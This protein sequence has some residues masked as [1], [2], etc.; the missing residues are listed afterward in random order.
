MGVYVASPH[1]GRLSNRRVCQ[2]LSRVN[3]QSF[4]GKIPAEFFNNATRVRVPTIK[5]MVLLI[6][7]NEKCIWVRRNPMAQPTDGI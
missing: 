3:T 2:N 6:T 5:G 4:N 7:H 1:R